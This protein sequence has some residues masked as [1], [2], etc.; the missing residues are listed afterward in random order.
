MSSV[1]DVYLS[2]DLYFSFAC[3]SFLFALPCLCHFSYYSVNH[4]LLWHTNKL[5]LERHN[6]WKV[7]EPVW[8]LSYLFWFVSCGVHTQHYNLIWDP[9][10]CVGVS[11]QLN[12]L[13]H[14]FKDTFHGSSR[15][16]NKFNLAVISLKNAC[17][18]VAVVLINMTSWKLSGG[19]TVSGPL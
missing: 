18:S 12:T 14:T 1:W 11:P 15:Q 5:E 13:K 17:C 7:K 10:N 8:N 16:N 19:E 3:I 2:L 4:V 9:H 6:V